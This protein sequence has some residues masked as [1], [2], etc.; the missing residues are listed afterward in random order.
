MAKGTE[1]LESDIQ[2]LF[3]DKD[4]LV[5]NKPAGLVVHPDGHTKEVTLVDWILSRNPELKE[6]GEPI[7][8]A[9][10]EI[11]FR[12][13]VVH[14]LDR[15]TSGVLVIAK[16][17]PAYLHLKSQFKDREIRKVYRTFVYG[18]MPVEGGIIDRPIGRSSGDFRKWTAERGTRGELRPAVTEWKLLKKDSNVSYLE[19]YPKTGRTHQIRVHMKA[20][21]HPVVGD[22]LYAPNRASLLGFTRLALHSFQITVELPTGETKTFEAPLPQD[23]IEAEKQ[24]H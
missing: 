16:N 12:P 20:I 9:S 2:I 15:E 17:Q 5:I 21:N 14:R 6:V 23:F 13:G 19:V 24:V 1:G 8:L 22:T 18:P 3:E 4:V 7:T 11:L 10:G